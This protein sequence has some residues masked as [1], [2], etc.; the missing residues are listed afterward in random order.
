MRTIDL[1]IADSW[2]KFTGSRNIPYLG[3][4]A[5]IDWAEKNPKLVQKLYAAYK[6][7]AEWVVANPDAAAKV[8][9]PKGTP[10]DHKAIAELIR[11]NDR[12]GMNVQWAS[13]VRKEIN[14][15][16]A[17][18]KIDRHPPVGSLRGDDLPGARQMSETAP[19]TGSPPPRTHA[20][21]GGKTAGVVG[22]AVR[23]GHG[24]LAIRL[25]VLSAVPVSLADR[26]V[27]ALHR[28]LHRRHRCSRM[29]WSTVL[30]ILAGL[31]GS[32]VIGVVLALLMVRSRAR[33]QVPV[34]D[35]DVV[36]G[37]S[38]A[39][40][41]G[42]RHHLV[43]RRR[44]S[45]HLHHG[46]DDAAGVYLPGA[47]RAARDVARPDGNGVQLPADAGQSCSG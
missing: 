4:A 26:R 42:V 33:R 3:V 32:F 19:Q 12:L 38:R 13:D 21:R 22:S 5:H 14:S 31:A 36:S 25:A 16:Y 43:S 6:E 30:R 37:H 44:V 46:D 45:H 17:A 40:L 28:N 27:L 15:V 8:I 41:G 23:R 34:A 11:A 1:A 29:W 10:D 9:L 2:K 39:V 35:P 20:G 47:G 24:A 18:G 7:A